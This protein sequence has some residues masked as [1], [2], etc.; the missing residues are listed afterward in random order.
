MS[1]RTDGGA[2]H[3]TP[4]PDRQAVPEPSRPEETLDSIVEN[5]PDLIVRFDRALRHV[6]VNARVERTLGLPRDSI[7]GRTN[8]ELGFPEALVATWEGA[9]RTAF[10]TGQPQR[11]EFAVPEEDEDHGGRLYESRI[12]PE[13]DADG[14]VRSVLG[15]T[16]DVTPFREVIAAWQHDEGPYR[17]TLD[18]AQAG[19]FVIQDMRFRYV[20]PALAQ[21]FG[22]TPDEMEERMGPLDLVLPEYREEVEQRVRARIDGVVGVPYEVPCLARDGGVR[23]VVAWG[24]GMR[25]R[26]RPATIGTAIDVTDQRRAERALRK[27][28]EQL[29]MITSQLPCLLWTT[30]RGLRLEHISGAAQ[31]DLEPWLNARAGMRLDEALGPL[32][33][34]ARTGQRFLA[35]HQRAIDGGVESL[36]CEL[37]GRVY[38]IRIEPR[39]DRGGRVSGVIGL[40][41]DITSRKEAEDQLRTLQAELARVMRV[42]ML[43]GLAS[44][45]AHELNQPLSAIISYADVCRRRVDDAHGGELIDKVITQGRRAAAIVQRMRRLVRKAPVERAA[46]DINA[47]VRESE[48]FVDWQAR[49]QGIGIILELDDT[50]PPVLG[51]TVQIQQVLLN[52]VRNAMD[53]LQS[54]DQRERWLTICT[55]TVP[56]NGQVFAEVRVQDTGPG[57]SESTRER[58]LDPLFTTR[59]DGLGFGLPISDMIVQ[60]HGGRL[61]LPEAGAGPTFRFTLPLYRRGLPRGYR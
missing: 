30:D 29:R 18:A 31:D 12:V 5:A 24:V 34:D 50:I 8:R 6:Y 10:D 17:L 19:I 43:E 58:L 37:A 59:H 46:V 27:Q 3:R 28:E 32:P 57:I 23:Q 21:L 20:N 7:L 51:D 42:G 33:G 35:A 9:L 44:G 11:L 55:R 13:Y 47:L 39:H 2:I 16:R 22:Y 41:V 14:R 60:S 40:A 52:L 38:D 25:Y 48:A 49:E 36:D 4:K 26:G 15:F 54:S 56:E 45:L 1:G 53:A 61:V